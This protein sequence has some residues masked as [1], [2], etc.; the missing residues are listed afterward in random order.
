MESLQLCAGIF[1]S[2]DLAI[3]EGKSSRKSNVTLG[4]VRGG[5][6]YLNERS[7]LFPVL[8]NLPLRHQ[9]IVQPER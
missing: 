3:L 9:A 4:G 6:T 5:R 2:V 1:A 8:T 7:E